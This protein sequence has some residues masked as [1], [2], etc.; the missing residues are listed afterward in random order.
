[1]QALQPYVFKTEI[2]ASVDEMHVY[3]SNSFI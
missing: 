1:M 2:Y 3:V